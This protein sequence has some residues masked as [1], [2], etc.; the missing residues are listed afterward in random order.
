MAVVLGVTVSSAESAH[1]APPATEEQYPAEIPQYKPLR[2]LEDYPH[3]MHG[4]EDDVFDPIKHV[5]LEGV[6]YVSFGGQTRLQ[7]ELLEG[8][9]RPDVVPRDSVLLVRN[10]VHADVHLALGLRVF[11]QLGSHLALGDPARTGPPTRTPSTSN[12]CSS[13]RGRSSGTPSSSR[14]PAARRCRSAGP[15][16]G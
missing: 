13:N 12:R 2:Y 5:P 16:A 11:T 15:R 7:Y 9:T 6:G 3:R 8:L 10:L 4:R 14:A 1:A